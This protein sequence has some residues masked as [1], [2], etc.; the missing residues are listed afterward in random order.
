MTHFVLTRHFCLASSMEPSREM[1]GDLARPPCGAGSRQLPTP[2]WLAS[3]NGADLTTCSVSILRRGHV[4]L[5]PSTST[6][7]GISTDQE[8]RRD[9]S[10]L[11]SCTSH[12]T[13]RSTT[14]WYLGN[15]AR[16]PSA[17]VLGGRTP[18]VQKNRRTRAHHAPNTLRQKTQV[19]SIS[20][21]ALWTLCAGHMGSGVSL[22][23]GNMIS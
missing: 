16:R 11:H 3:S 9:V 4:L 12:L 23:Q 20:H 13:R 2:P 5:S 14:L 10:S 21:G 7:V 22:R 1:A 17:E 18:R 6:S 19:A 15:V 8:C